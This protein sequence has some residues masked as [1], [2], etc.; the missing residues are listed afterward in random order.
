[1]YKGWMKACP[2]HIVAPTVTI[3]AAK[4]PAALWSSVCSFLRWSC[5][6]K[7][8]ESLVHFFYHPEQR[9][10][11]A[12]VFP[13]KAQAWTVKADL[14]AT[15]WLKR[16]FVSAGTIHH[17]N[18][19]GASQSGVDKGDEVKSSGLHMTLGSLRS[20][21]MSVHIRLILNGVE[22]LPQGLGDYVDH[23][24]PLNPQFTT[25]E[26]PEEWKERLKIET[27]KSGGHSVVYIQ[28][29]AW[30]DYVDQGYSPSRSQYGG[31]YWKPGGGAT[32][33]AM[34]LSAQYLADG[35]TKGQVQVTSVNGVM[36][37]RVA[38]EMAKILVAGKKFVYG[39]VQET[40]AYVTT[41]KQGQKLLMLMTPEQHATMVVKGIRL[42]LA[43]E[44]EKRKMQRGAL[45][46]LTLTNGDS[47]PYYSA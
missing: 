33:W 24:A 16:G 2:D 42:E 4:I 20:A 8:V 18:D 36:T 32:D 45:R 22:Y 35:L 9:V 7:H 27:F 17:H 38:P 11:E 39:P 26:F 46:T 29:E 37:L 40:T 28:G 34:C 25:A 30:G 14:D 3:T 5:V 6:E 13:Q 41:S 10:W 44:K 21:E 12:N 31:T 43:S 23:P 47:V 1:M 15:P 19:G